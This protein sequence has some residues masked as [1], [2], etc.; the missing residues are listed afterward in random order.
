MLKVLKV[1]SEEESRLARSNI[2][3]LR[4]WEDK[5]STHC[6]KDYRKRGRCEDKED[7]SISDKS[8][9]PGATSKWICPIDCYAA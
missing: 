4:N 7:G 9:E 1:A 8:E 5:D 6:G 3:N 2:S